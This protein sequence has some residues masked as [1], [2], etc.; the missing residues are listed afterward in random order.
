MDDYE[1]YRAAGDPGVC[2]SGRVRD[3]SDAGD[4]R[5]RT[6]WRGARGVEGRPWSEGYIRDGIR[7]SERD[8][9]WSE[10]DMA[11]IDTGGFESEGAGAG[12]EADGLGGAMGNF[13]AQRGVERDGSDEP[14]CG[15]SK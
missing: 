6:L 9:F 15:F 1:S 13:L 4:R 5:G 14:D 12:V 7:Y 2:V 3:D 11:R 8:E 10:S